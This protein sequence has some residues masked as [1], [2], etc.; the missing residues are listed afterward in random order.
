[1]R[2]KTALIWGVVLCCAMLGGCGTKT[3]DDFIPEG[4]TEAPN[5]IYSTSAS[6]N[7]L[8]NT[9][10][11]ADGVITDA[12]NKTSLFPYYV[13]ETNEGKIALM[14]TGE[15]KEL[16]EG[17]EF[18]A[19]FMY[20]GMSAT[21]DMPSGYYIGVIDPE[22]LPDEIPSIFS[23]KKAE[24][25]KTS[26]SKSQTTEPT[27]D[28]STDTEK[29]SD[30]T[31]QKI[32]DAKKLYD[33]VFAP[34][35]NHMKAQ[36]PSLLERDIENDGYLYKLIGDN[37]YCIYADDESVYETRVYVAYFERDSGIV[38]PGDVSFVLDGHEAVIMKNMSSDGDLDYDTLTVDGEEVKNTSLA[39]SIIFK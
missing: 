26:T 11:Y 27:Q 29:T 22:N 23:E 14:S 24:L 21:I 38:T 15:I 30:D 31:S 8:E 7:G 18:R 28:V 32:S 10:M 9:F 1:M 34:I 36:T 20:M 17:K 37:H 12:S 6:E 19:F 5:T 39:R 35:A 2:K 16:E 4:Y 33:D 3:I 13:L 25:E